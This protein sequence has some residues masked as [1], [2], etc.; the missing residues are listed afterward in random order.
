MPYCFEI[1]ISQTSGFCMGRSFLNGV[2]VGLA[3]E[4]L[5][6]TEGRFSQGG[7]K[8]VC[9]GDQGSEPSVSIIYEEILDQLR[10]KLASQ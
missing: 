10:E 6:T 3:A 9:S 1:E 5:V 8:I 2:R 4:E 7:E